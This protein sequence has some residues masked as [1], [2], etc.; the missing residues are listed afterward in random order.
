MKRTSKL[1][2]MA[3]M[4]FFLCLVA[5]PS[6]KADP[7][8]FGN[9]LALQNGGLTTVNLLANPGVTL[10]GPQI[11]FLVDING[12]IPAGGT[13]LE[14]SFLQGLGPAVVQ[15]FPIP[16][17]PGIDPPY[18]QL[19]TIN[20]LGATFAGLPATLTITIPEFGSRTFS[21]LVAEPVPEP[22][23]ILLLSLGGLGLWSRIRRRRPE[24]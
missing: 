17:F 22:A 11:S 13:V 15:T 3:A 21:F 7:I 2:V 18:T 8:T 10:F 6:A 19:F 14:I 5:A 16:L 4:M 20:S 9:V 24:N 23:S 1:G 12:T